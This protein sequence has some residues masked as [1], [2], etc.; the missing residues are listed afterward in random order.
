MSNVKE[1]VSS[2]LNEL[3]DDITFEDLMYHLYVKHKIIRGK[4]QIKAVQVYSQEEVEEL[5][6][7]WRK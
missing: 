3:P 1:M 5:A 2:L 6:K 7:T 4:E